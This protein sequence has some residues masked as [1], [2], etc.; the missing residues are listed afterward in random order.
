MRSCVAP[1][2]PAPPRAGRPEQLRHPWAPAENDRAQEPNQDHTKVL[3]IYIYIFSLRPSASGG[4][5]V[6]PRGRGNELLAA[7]F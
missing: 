6:G 3:N 7:L 1:P 4:G 5:D 2:R